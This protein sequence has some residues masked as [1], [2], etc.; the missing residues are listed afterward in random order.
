MKKLFLLGAMVCALGMG[1]SAQSSDTTGGR[2]IDVDL[3]FVKF[4]GTV[5]GVSGTNYEEPIPFAIVRCRAA[6]DKIFADT[7]DFD[8][9]FDICLT[10]GEYD[11]EIQYIGFKP[12]QQHILVTDSKPVVIKMRARACDDSEDMIIIRYEYPT[13]IEMGPDAA[14]QKMEIEGVQVKVR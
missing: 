7:T 1:V 11:I 14:T 3:R 13:K 6:N 10:E 4:N 8:G 9:K 12:F 5:I 2:M